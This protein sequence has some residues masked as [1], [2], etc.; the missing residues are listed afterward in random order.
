MESIRMAAGQHSRSGM[1]WIRHSVLAA[2]PGLGGVLTTAT[3]LCLRRLTAT[4]TEL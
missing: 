2:A 1:M 4:A 3:A